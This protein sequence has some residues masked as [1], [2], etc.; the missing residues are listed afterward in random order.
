LVCNEGVL[1]DGW[2]RELLASV[3]PKGL[4][5]FHPEDGGDMYL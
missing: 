4:E 2:E 1:H 5:V 3:T